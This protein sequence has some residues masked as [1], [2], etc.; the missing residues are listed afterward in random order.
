LGLDERRVIG[1]V[2]SDSVF[3]EELLKLKIG[4][5]GQQI[6]FVLGDCALG[7]N[8][9]NRR[10][11]ADLH[12]LLVIGERLLSQRQRLLLHFYVFISGHQVPVNVLNLSDC[13]Y[14]LLSERLFSSDLGVLGLHH[15][16][17]VNSWS[18]P[19][20]QMLSD[21]G[22]KIRVQSRIQSI[23]SIVGGLPVVVVSN[24]KRSAGREALKVREVSNYLVLRQ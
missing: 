5:R 3:H 23:E 16:T 1:Q 8:D 6:L 19:L 10:H 7:A 17:A 13:A 11:G 20:Q 2:A 15:E 24:G 22:T 21:A 18:E 9:F 14:H 12:L 4:A